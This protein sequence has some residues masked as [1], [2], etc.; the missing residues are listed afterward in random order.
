MIWILIPYVALHAANLLLLKYLA[1]LALPAPTTLCYRGL[2]CA[3]V[4]TAVGLRT[5]TSLLP[6]FPREQAVRFLIAGA[7]LYLLTQSFFYA[8]ASTVGWISRLDTALLIWLGPLA[9][10]ETSTVR[11][12]LAGTL[13]AGAI[14]AGMTL[15]A[16]GES[17]WGYCLALL[18]T[19]GLTTGYILMKRTGTKETT[20]VVA[21]V[22]A[23]ALLFFGATLGGLAQR[24]DPRVL[25]ALL[26]GICMYTIYDLTLRLYRRMDIAMA[27]YPTLLSA[28]IVIPLENLLLNTPLDVTYSMCIAVQIVA[29]G[30]LLSTKA[31]PFLHACVC[32]LR[33]RLVLL[34]IGA[35]HG[36]FARTSRSRSRR[37]FRTREIGG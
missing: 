16:D 24:P 7:S 31:G 25:G 30:A 26:S 27:E 17:L 4:A 15:R 20:P 21:L 33:Q 34:P 19:G 28:A 14:V 12:L 2:G 18:A 5:R 36:K 3:L 11:R 29:L 13:V 35:T 22:A 6:K 10:S 32:R 8:R 23:L 9:G 1:V 37:R